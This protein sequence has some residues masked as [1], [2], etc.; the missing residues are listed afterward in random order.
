MEPMTTTVRRPRLPGLL[1]LPLRLAPERLHG[2]IAA[3]ILDRVFARERAGGELDFLAGR[4]VRVE[5]EDAGAAFGVLLGS[6]GFRAAPAGRADLVV[7]GTL[8][9]YLQLLTAREDPD[10]LFFQRRLRMA[11]D[12][13]LGVH[14]K[15]FLAGVDMASLPLAGLVQPLLSRGLTAYERWT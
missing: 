14:L 3:R 12:A 7:S 6:G 15:N 4:T 8:H 10:T 5:L 2:L 11:G 13:A 9:D 1:G